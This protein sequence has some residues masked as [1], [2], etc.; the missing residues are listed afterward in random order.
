MHEFQIIKKYFQDPAASD[1]DILL[2]IGD[3]AAILQIP[4]AEQVVVCVDTIVSGT[5]F[6]PDTPAAEIAHQALAVNLS[7]IAA[8]GAKPRWFT[9]AL[10]LPHAEEAW[11]QEFSQGLFALAQQHQ[12][13]LIGGDT[14]QGP[15]AVTIQVLGTLPDAATALLRSGAQVG[16]KIF[17]T[18]TVGDAGL[19]L[20]M[21]RDAIAVP[22]HYHDYLRHRYQ[23]PEPRVQ[24]GQ[25]LRDLATSA[26]D[27][28]DG[29]AAD[30]N[31][32]LEQSKVGAVIETSQLP[33][34][35]EL[36]QSVAPKNA[37]YLA[38]TAG[39]DYELCFTVPNHLQKEVGRIARET[40]V[41]CTCIGEIT[42]ATGLR[43]LD[44]Q[45]QPLILDHLGWE[46]FS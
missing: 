37:L 15:L 34:S 44:P 40:G 39:G 20:A 4:S 46:H 24:L 31:H 12:V 18:G 10:T 35:L 26:I 41:P 43:I 16:D 1:K 30:L 19:G 38:L 32:I 45:L 7:D 23:H 8:M 25:Q 36:K 14:T 9:L 11:L 29:L 3:D 21:L 2:G 13:H 33:L 42:A 5:H 27:I 28:S 6:L 22:A 17:V